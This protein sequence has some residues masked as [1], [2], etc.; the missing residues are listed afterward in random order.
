MNENK[1]H[2]WWWCISIQT[3]EWNSFENYKM[4]KAENAIQLHLGKST[5]QGMWNVETFM[6]HAR[7][8]PKAR[9]NRNE[10]ESLLQ[11]AKY[12]TMHFK[13]M[14]FIKILLYFAVLRL[15]KLFSFSI[16]IHCTRI[17]ANCLCLYNSESFFFYFFFL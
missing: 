15:V 5:S 1:W 7:L 10:N 12:L 17:F 2:W 8:R 3:L 9:D 11:I 6:M 13:R 16:F 14:L 4:E